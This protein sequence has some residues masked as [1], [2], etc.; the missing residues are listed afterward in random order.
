MALPLASA[1]NTAACSAVITQHNNASPT[2][3][4]ATITSDIDT[5]SAAGLFEITDVIMSHE[6][7]YVLE[8][9][10]YTCQMVNTKWRVSWLRP[11]R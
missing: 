5:A 11:K 10:G 4:L 1:S 8:S 2:G 6:E 7:A 3:P 9:L